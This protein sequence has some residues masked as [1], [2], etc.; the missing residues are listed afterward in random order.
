MRESTVE[1]FSCAVYPSGLISV[2]FADHEGLASSHFSVHRCWMM[3]RLLGR[4]SLTV[5]R[6]N[7]NG[8]YL[9]RWAYAYSAVPSLQRHQATGCLVAS[10]NLLMTNSG[11]VKNFHSCVACAPY[12]SVSSYMWL[13]LI[14][15]FHLVMKSHGYTIVLSGGIILWFSHAIFS[16]QKF[17]ML[18]YTSFQDIW[19]SWA[20][21]PT[22]RPKG[23]DCWSLK[24]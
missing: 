12:A 19:K 9:E 16:S 5:V 11:H 18:K 10:T 2:V 14:L 8:L 17:I 7:P 13:F 1:I 15:F 3:R 4:M 20:R 6:W 23:V 24:R 22:L 21:C